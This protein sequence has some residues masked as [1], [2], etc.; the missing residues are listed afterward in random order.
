MSEK[1]T[2][3]DICKKNE[4]VLF[5]DHRTSTESQKINLCVDC[6]IKYGVMT[7]D[8]KVDL[9]PQKVIDILK[10]SKV[11]LAAPARETQKCPRCGTDRARF[12]E[13][14]TAGCPRCWDVF[15]G[16]AKEFA[17]S[18]VRYTGKRK[19]TLASKV[20]AAIRDDETSVKVAMLNSRLSHLTSS[21]RYEEAIKVRDAIRRIEKTSGHAVRKI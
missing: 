6:G 3:C 17:K 9:F 15:V 8:F 20:R 12:I 16:N 2:Y 1:K 21:E 14:K 7:S 11:Q 10:N 19:R 13:T 18:S 4:A 5:L